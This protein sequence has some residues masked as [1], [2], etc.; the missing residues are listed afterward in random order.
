MF[1]SVW[2]WI[3]CAGTGNAY[4]QWKGSATAKLNVRRIPAK[5][6]AIITQIKK[7]QEVTIRDKRECWYKIAIEEKS[8]GFM[9]WVYGR[10]IKKIPVE[11]IKTSSA[12]NQIRD[13]LLPEELKTKDIFLTQPTKS[14][15][16]NKTGKDKK[17]GIVPYKDM[18]AQNGTTPLAKQA[19]DISRKKEYVNKKEAMTSSA[20]KDPVEKMPTQKPPLGKASNV[21]GRPYMPPLK[22]S[23]KVTDGAHW[24]P[25]GKSAISGKQL[26]IAP[27]K[28]IY[29]TGGGEKEV[30]LETDKKGTNDSKSKPVSWVLV[31][32]V[33]K[34]LAAVLSC[35]AIIFAFRARQLAIINYDS[36]MK[37]Q[38][39]FHHSDPVQSL[40]GC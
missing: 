20:E 35:L 9:G 34:L 21:T 14:S 11:Y 40:R 17:P 32:G 23:P 3:Y 37:L 2:L 13:A 8:Y 39:T 26:N 16:I 22:E 15:F 6:G 28:D 30:F 25:F 29:G 36:I 31:G 24:K 1:F 12:I 27:V 10:Y 18:P 33:I 5:N 4:E 7:G 38:H 19:D